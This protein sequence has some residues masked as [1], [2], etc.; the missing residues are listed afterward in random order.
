MGLP[1]D[2]ALQSLSLWR[3]ISIKRVVKQNVYKKEDVCRESIGRLE[4]G[5]RDR[6]IERLG[7]REERR[8]RVV[9]ALDVV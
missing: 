6:Q 7:K 4:H 8:K 3:K 5:E 9:H 2:V 1:L